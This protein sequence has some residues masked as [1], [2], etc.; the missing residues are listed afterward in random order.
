MKIYQVAKHM[1]WE[2]DYVLDMPIEAFN[3]VYELMVE[4]AREERMAIERERLKGSASSAT[5]R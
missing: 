1:G 4:E 5:L 3:Q 2:L